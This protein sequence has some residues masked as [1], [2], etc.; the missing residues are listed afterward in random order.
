M[1]GKQFSNTVNISGQPGKIV[2]QTAKPV[3]WPRNTDPKK[4]RV[5]PEKLLD[6]FI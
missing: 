6:L 3:G 4:L 5:E 2:G 1:N